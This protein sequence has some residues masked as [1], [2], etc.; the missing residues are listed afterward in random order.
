[1]DINETLSELTALIDCASSNRYG[2]ALNQT[3][4]YCYRPNNTPNSI[5]AL[6][7]TKRTPANC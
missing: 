3:L 7:R 2:T 4:L 5:V 6:N 1:M